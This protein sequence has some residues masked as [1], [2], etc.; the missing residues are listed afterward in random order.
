[1]A[2]QT[3]KLKTGKPRKSDL[4]DVTIDFSATADTLDALGHITSLSVVEI[5]RQLAKQYRNREELMAATRP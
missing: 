5:G 1:M 4:H 3:K 2:K